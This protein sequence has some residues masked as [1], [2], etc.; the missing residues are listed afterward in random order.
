MITTTGM[1]IA[2]LVTSMIGT[3]VMAYNS[4]Q[5]GKAQQSLNNYNAAVSDQGALDAERDARIKATAQRHQ[6]EQI[7]ARQ[8]TLFAHAGVVGGTGSPLMVQ[9]AQAGELEMAALEQEQ[10]GS[11]QAAR[12]RTEGVLDRM[13]GKS[14]RAGG[15]MGAVGTILQGTGNAASTW[16]TYK[17]V[18]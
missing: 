8:R 18:K 13:A 9:V 4:Y 6:S 3:G 17:G 15:T 7:K 2:G 16:A 11:A 5:Q 14:A 12:L 1:L 10:A